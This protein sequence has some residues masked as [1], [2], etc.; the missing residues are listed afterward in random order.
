MKLHRALNVQRGD[1][2][3]FVGAGG[4]TAALIALGHELAERGWRVLATTTTHIQPDDLNLM[5]LTL[6]A[7]SPTGEIATALSEQP[8]VFLHSGKDDGQVSGVSSQRIQQLLDAVNSDV[9]LIEA[10]SANGLAMKAPYANEPAI[11]PDTTL[12]VPVVG[13]NVLGQPLDETHVYNATA[14]N[15]RYGFG[16]GNRVKSPWVAQV[17]RDETLGLKNIPAK[18]RITALINQVPQNGYTR[19]RARLIAQLALRVQASTHGEQRPSRLHGIAM[20][21]VRAADPIYEVQRPIGAIVLAAGMSTRMGDMKIL[22]PWLNGRTIIE[23][24]IHQLHLARVDHITVVTGH[25]G[26]EVKERVHP[27]GVTV[28]HNKDYK[29]GEMLSSVK[30]GLR[31]M[32]DHIAATMIVLGDQP[33]IQAKTVHMVMGAYAEGQGDIVAPSYKMQRGHPILIDKRYWHE[34]LDLPEDS[35]PRAV[36]KANQDQIAYVLVNNDSVLRDV[37]TPEAYREERRRAGLE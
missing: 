24:I 7:E 37:D 33:R 3:A 35:A 26:H 11:P 27:L 12:V 6:P 22:L 19:A 32:P 13:L 25:R 17:L 4:K 16:I 5:P 31:A 36:I 21:S 30:A 23:H 9:L 18:A 1:V 20:G 34:F 14:I 28:A 29:T 8:F 2:I 15:R 10:D